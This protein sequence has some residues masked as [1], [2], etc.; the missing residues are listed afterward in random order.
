MKLA[1]H[2]GNAPEGEW[3]HDRQTTVKASGWLAGDSWRVHGTCIETGQA[4]LSKPS[5]RIP[6]MDPT[7]QQSQQL[8]PSSCSPAA[9]G[10]CAHRQLAGRACIKSEKKPLP[11]VSYDCSRRV[12]ALLPCFISEGDQIDGSGKQP[13]YLMHARQL[14]LRRHGPSCRAPSPPHLALLQQVASRHAAAQQVR[15]VCC[16]LMQHKAGLRQGAGQGGEVHGR[17]HT[18]DRTAA[19]NLEQCCTGIA[20]CC[21]GIECCSPTAAY[22]HPPPSLQHPPHQSQA[23]CAACQRPAA[24]WGRLP[25]SAPVPMAATAAAAAPGPSAAP[26]LRLPQLHLPARWP[27]R[28]AGR[29]PWL[30]LALGTGA[31]SP[32]GGGPPTLAGRRRAAARRLAS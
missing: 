31:D 32:P 3:G 2:H 23:A 29:G 19:A 17:M 5:T 13:C 22:L 6:L 20:C 1:G 12:H 30:P 15:C 16:A 10:P 7:G 9:A 25:N 24:R 8:Q 11:T 27:R 21:T 14:G 4:G 26:P 28:L 18:P